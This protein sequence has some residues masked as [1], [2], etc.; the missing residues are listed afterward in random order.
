MLANTNP[1]NVSCPVAC[2]TGRAIA[3][4]SDRADG[5]GQFGQSGF[6]AECCAGSLL[7]AA[8]ACN[9]IAGA[10]PPAYRRF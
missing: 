3:A 8:N 4:H 9:F 5:L 10:Q 6:E 7:I 1:G 2:E